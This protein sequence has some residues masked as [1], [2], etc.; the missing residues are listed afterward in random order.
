MPQTIEGYQAWEVL[1]KLSEPNLGIALSIA[2]SMA[3]DRDLLAELLPVGVL[4]MKQGL[5]DSN[6]EKIIN[7]T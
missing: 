5:N 2:E 7:Q 4:A 3:F 1:L 6:S